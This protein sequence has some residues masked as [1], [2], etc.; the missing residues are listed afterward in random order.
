MGTCIIGAGKLVCVCIY[1]FSLYVQRCK[2]LSCC[3]YVEIYQ[4]MRLIL[5]YLMFPYI[6]LKWTLNRETDNSTHITITHKFIETHNGKRYHKKTSE[7]R[8]QCCTENNKRK[9]CRTVIISQWFHPFKLQLLWEGEYNTN[10]TSL[11]LFL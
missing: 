1:I 6:Y 9:Q 3:L 5:P 8:Y 11:V 7:T 4:P 10:V 2:L